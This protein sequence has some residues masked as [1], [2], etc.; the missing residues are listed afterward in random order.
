MSHPSTVWQDQAICHLTDA[1]AFT[2][3]HPGDQEVVRLKVLC[4]QCPV[5]VECARVGV[6]TGAPGVWAGV[7][8]PTCGAGLGKARMALR[9]K[10][11]L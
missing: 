7:H 10:A 9:L 6:E 11:Q 8:V 5:T 1:A 2:A 3:A 4:S